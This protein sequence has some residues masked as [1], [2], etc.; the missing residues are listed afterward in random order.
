MNIHTHQMGGG[1][2]VSRKSSG[3]SNEKEVLP[4]FGSS[5]DYP[6]VP[7]G[8]TRISARMI[9]GVFLSVCVLRFTYEIMCAVNHAGP[10]LG[11][12]VVLHLSRVSKMCIFVFFIVV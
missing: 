10:L 8:R 12:Q 2:A 3:M 1:V 11:N 6:L 4:L 5:L 9:G 7:H